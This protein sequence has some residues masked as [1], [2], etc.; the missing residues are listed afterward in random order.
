MGLELGLN[1]CNYACN[2]YIKVK[3][4]YLF[5]SLGMGPYDLLARHMVTELNAVIVSV[6]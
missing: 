2:Y 6:E 3:S 4:I 1:A 5:L